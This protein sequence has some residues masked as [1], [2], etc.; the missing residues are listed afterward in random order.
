MYFLTEGVG[1]EKVQDPFGNT[2]TYSKNGIVHSAGLSVA[3]QRDG[4]GRI[5][6]ITDPQGQSLQ[7][8]YT[9]QGGLAAYTDPRGVTTASQDYDGQGRL[10]AVWHG[11]PMCVGKQTV[12]S[13]T[14]II[15]TQM[16]NNL[17]ISIGSPSVESF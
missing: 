5:T 9:P 14:K 2:L 3:F 8:S 1:L 16:R 4:Q 13:G 10:T 17:V 15:A 11:S 6:R 12:L 7:Y